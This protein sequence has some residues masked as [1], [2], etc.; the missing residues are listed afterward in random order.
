M[1]QKVLSHRETAYIF[2]SLAS[3]LHTG[4]GTADA[5]YLLAQEEPGTLGQILTRAGEL[6]DCGDTLW[7]TLEKCGV[8]P[9]SSTGMVHVG[10]QTGRTEEALMALADFHEERDRTLRQLRSTLGYPA[11]LLVLMLAVIGVLLVEVLPVFDSVYASLGNRLTGIAGGLLQL[12]QAL[13]ALLPA[14]FVLLLLTALAVSAYGFCPPFRSALTALWQKKFGD[15]GIHRKFNNARFARALAMGIASG[16]PLEE[17]V[18]LARSLLD[19]PGAAARCDACTAALE[20]GTPLTDA[21]SSTQLLPLY[22]C[23]LLAVGLKGGNAERM[24]DDI[25][26]RMMEEASQSLE[27][28]VEKVEPAIVLACAVLV[29]AILLA[30]M[31][32]LM[33]ILAAIG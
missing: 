7:E 25:A 13:K 14:L 5:F 11:L 6:L 23:R 8:F 27:N 21:L 16:L 4:L 30:V 10:E 31:L 1:D 2:R 15:R 12:G 33:H 24:L 22:A 17:A 18:I 19:S 28:T 32:P 29:G 20:A 9:A 26:K 3:L